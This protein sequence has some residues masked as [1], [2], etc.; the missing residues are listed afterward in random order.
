MQHVCKLVRVVPDISRW[1]R[2]GP[3]KV[4]RAHDD[5]T[6]PQPDEGREGEEGD[7]VEQERRTAQQAMQPHGA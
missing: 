3:L 4:A 6:D 1:Q 2:D 7:P 5:A